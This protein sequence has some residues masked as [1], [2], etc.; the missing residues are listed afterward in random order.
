VIIFVRFLLKKSNQ[1]K[2]NLKKKLKPVQ[3]DWFRFG[4]LEQKPVQTD[5]AWFFWFGSV[6]SGLA[7]VFS[8]FFGFMLIK[9][10]RSVF[11]FYSLVFSVVFYP[12]FSV[13]FSPQVVRIA[14]CSILQLK[15]DSCRG[16]AV[17]HLNEDSKCIEKNCFRQR[18]ESR[19]R[20]AKC[21]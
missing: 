10:N 20:S 13:F 16:R 17:F 18:N 12:V 21:F 14:T 6:F 3:T 2:K 7:L 15:L 1:I 8:G 9:P 11:F 5:L 4:F 19:L